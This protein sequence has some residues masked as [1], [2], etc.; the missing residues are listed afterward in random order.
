VCQ[1]QSSDQV[2]MDDVSEELKVVGKASFFL[3][4]LP[5]PYDTSGWGMYVGQFPTC[6]VGVGMFALKLKL[7][8]PMISRIERNPI[9]RVGGCRLVP[10]CRVG[11]CGIVPGANFE[12]SP[13]KSD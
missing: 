8:K 5:L 6:R 3:F 13:L 10:T 11:G 2:T 9:C 7:A 1:S 4:F 12:L